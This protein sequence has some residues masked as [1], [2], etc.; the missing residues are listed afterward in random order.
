MYIRVNEPFGR[1]FYWTICKLVPELACWKEI[2]Q[3][4]LLVAKFSGFLH[5]SP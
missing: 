5:M 1:V 3:E 4:V 2:A